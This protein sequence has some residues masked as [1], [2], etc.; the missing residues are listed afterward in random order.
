MNLELFASLCYAVAMARRLY[1]PH[2]DQIDLSMLLGALSD[3]IRRSI[4]RRLA[5][6]RELHCGAFGD[7]GEKSNLC[8]HFAKLRE[9]GVTRTR[10]EGP[11]RYISLRLDELEARYPGLLSSVI[12]AAEHEEELV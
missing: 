11:F 6:T 4:V 3:P 2:V 10:I 9:A 5:R 1:H 7:E 12:A 8:Y